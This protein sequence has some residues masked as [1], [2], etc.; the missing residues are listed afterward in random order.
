MFG[1]KNDGPVTAFEGRGVPQQGVTIIA[2]GVKVEGDFQSP[3]DVTIEGEVEGKIATGGLLTIGS[4]A[5]V[6]ADVK[7]NDAAVAGRIE[8]NIAVKKRLELKSTA[9]IIGDVTCEVISIESGASLHGRVAV[10]APLESPIPLAAGSKI[11]RH[12]IVAGEA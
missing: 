8:G 11:E 1:T 4:E 12:R 9:K 7:A 2:R 5:R 10:G 3:G 6:R